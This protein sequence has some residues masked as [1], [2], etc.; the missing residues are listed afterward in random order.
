MLRQDCRKVTERLGMIRSR[1]LSYFFIRS[2]LCVEKCQ[3]AQIRMQ[4][5][6]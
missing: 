2:S 6:S 4:I 3:F 1:T 5:Q